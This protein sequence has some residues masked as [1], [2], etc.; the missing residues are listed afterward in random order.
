M[1][2]GK[3]SE[4]KQKLVNL[5]ASLD[6]D[7][8]STYEQVAKELKA[9]GHDPEKV[10]DEIG[11]FVESAFEQAC[12][13]TEVR[14][15]TRDS[16]IV[17]EEPP[18]TARTGQVSIRLLDYFERRKAAAG[19]DTSL[20]MKLAADDG[21][22][23]RG[24]ANVFGRVSQLGAPI[25]VDDIEV[26]LIDCYGICVVGVP[27]TSEPVSLIVEGR[28]HELVEIEDFYQNCSDEVHSAFARHRFF[29]AKDLTMD[30]ALK[31]I[32]LAGQDADPE[33]H[34]RMTD[35]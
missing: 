8:D 3:Y 25:Q 1:T 30:M 23:D 12:T 24:S 14:E 35:Q 10:F 6:D 18:A 19:E 22:S 11:A 5:S 13:E 21:H 17:A 32:L 2:T 9:A 27:D 33:A 26:V 4:A 7:L 29:E 28:D 31:L 20:Q 34:L 15:A 16:S